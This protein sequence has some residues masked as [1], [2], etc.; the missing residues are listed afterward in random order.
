VSRGA[1]R[2]LRTIILGVA[3]LA[4]LLWAAVEQFGVPWQELQQ[5][6]L[7]TLLVVGGIIGAAALVTGCWLALRW[8]L[9]RRP[10]S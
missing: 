6:L 2:Y 1:R 5:L 9:G 7:A 3:A 10:G 8:L 4:V